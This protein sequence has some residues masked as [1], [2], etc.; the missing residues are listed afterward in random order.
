MKNSVTK[1]VFKEEELY[2][3]PITSTQTGPPLTGYDTQNEKVA[4][5]DHISVLN[6]DWNNNEIY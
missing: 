4:V 6:D 5:A 3:K 1:N 2:R